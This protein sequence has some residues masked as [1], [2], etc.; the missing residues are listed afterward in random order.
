MHRLRHNLA[1]TWLALF[2]LTLQLGMSFGHMHHDLKLHA[3]ASLHAAVCP[4]AANED[5]SSPEHNEQH[6]SCAICFALAIMQVALTSAAPV[7]IAAIEVVGC[8]LPA[9]STASQ[10]LQAA[11]MFQA[12]APPRTV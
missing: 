2:A 12:R 10:R 6:D 7:A 8:R 9:V 11:R 5:C 3:N 1:L 4:S